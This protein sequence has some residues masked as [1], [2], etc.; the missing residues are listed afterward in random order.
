MNRMVIM[1][2]A[3]GEVKNQWP[4]PVAWASGCLRLSI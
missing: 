2:M 4:R 1:I 3:A